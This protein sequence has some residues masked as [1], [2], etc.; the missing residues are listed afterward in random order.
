VQQFWQDVQDGWRDAGWG[1]YFVLALLPWVMLLA[2]VSYLVT[3]KVTAPPSAGFWLAVVPIVLGSLYWAGLRTGPASWIGR[4]ILAISVLLL[5]LLLLR[6]MRRTGETELV[7]G[8]RSHPVR[9]RG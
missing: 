6:R 5:V 9:V 3:G 4:L 1:D 8:H 7:P 2:L